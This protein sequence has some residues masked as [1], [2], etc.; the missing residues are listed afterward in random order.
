MKVILPVCLQVHFQEKA[1]EYAGMELH[2]IKQSFNDWV[3]VRKEAKGDDWW[4]SRKKDGKSVMGPAKGSM[5]VSPRVIHAHV[6]LKA[7]RPCPP[8]RTTPLRL[9][10]VELLEHERRAMA[11][12]ASTL[13]R[14]VPRVGA[15]L[16]H[17]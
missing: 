1:E 17:I 6:I 5:K 8:C 4:P 13:L 10:I 3:Q 7:Y 12:L 2:E 15:L 9:P 14:F 16:L 11:L